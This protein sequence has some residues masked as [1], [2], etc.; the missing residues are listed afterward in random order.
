MKTVLHSFAWVLLLTVA[1]SAQTT[2][3]R[4]DYSIFGQNAMYTAYSAQISQ[5]TQVNIGGTGAGQTFDFTGYTFTESSGDINY[6]DPATTP[7]AATFSDANYAIETESNGS[8]SYLYLKLT[9]DYLYHLGLATDFQG[10]TV[11][12][13]YEPDWP[14]MMFPASL[15]TS[16][17]YQSD[18]MTIAMGSTMSTQIDYE[19]DAAG[20]LLLPGGISEECIR[21]KSV[22]RRT[23]RFEVMGNVIENTSLTVQYSFIT[24]TG[25]SANALVDTN[26]V[27]SSTPSTTSLS[28][29]L[30]EGT[31]TSIGQPSAPVTLE[32]GAAYPNPVAT[33]ANLPLNLATSG[34]VTVDLYD[35]TGRFVK[36]MHSAALSQGSH[37]IELNLGNVRPGTYMLR[38][39]GAEMMGSTLLSKVK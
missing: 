9:D 11:L 1:V 39:H 19:V 31:S 15:G 21:L 27:N 29:T 25:I 10:N 13:D 33:K 30:T 38:V 26:D 12:F 2:I 16:W 14:T 18:P 3:T 8:F 6:V 35:L 37:D 5:G 32:L 23:N 7:H 4:S 22:E 28:Y 20:T 34:Q 24:K 36:T 17:S